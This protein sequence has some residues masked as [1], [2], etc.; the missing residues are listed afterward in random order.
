[1]RFG[2]KPR[3]WVAVASAAL[4][5]VCASCAGLAPLGNGNGGSG[6]AYPDNLPLPRG[7]TWVSATRA[8]H[9]IDGQVAPPAAEWADVPP[10]P[11]QA[12]GW[13]GLWADWRAAP[14]ADGT[15]DAPA[16]TLWLLAALD[17]DVEVDALEVRLRTGDG[18]TWAGRIPLAEGSEALWLRNGEPTGEART[19]TGAGPLPTDSEHM[20]RWVEIAVPT[21]PGSVRL[22]LRRMRAG[23]PIS[24]AGPPG[25][26]VEASLEIAGGGVSALSA[27][28]RTEPAGWVTAEPSVVPGGGLVHVSGWSTSNRSLPEGWDVVAAGQADALLRAPSDAAAWSV[29]VLDDG[30][31]AASPLGGPPFEPTGALTWPALTGGRVPAVVD[32]T[33]ATFAIDPPAGGTWGATWRPPIATPCTQVAVRTDASTGLATDAPDPSHRLEVASPGEDHIVQVAVEPASL[34][35]NSD[36]VLSCEGQ[37]VATWHLAVRGGALAVWSHREP[38]ITGLDA[39]ALGEALVRLDGAWFGTEGRVRVT[40]GDVGLEAVVTSWSDTHIEARLGAPLGGGP[41]TVVLERDDGHEATTTVATVDGA[42]E[43]GP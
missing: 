31:V 8:P 14:P 43:S 13:S 41:W 3:S 17:A 20:V 27:A 29:Q 18:A 40:S 4:A 39:A 32:P 11:L 22:R 21:P 42:G 1:M 2:F 36:W 35:P 16:G 37:P 33:G 12:E 28:A 38:V 30:T 15:T 5:G 10:I 9:T 26:L 23:G 34:G 25:I 19:A 24:I 6:A 7:R